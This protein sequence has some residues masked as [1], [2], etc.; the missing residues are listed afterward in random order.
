MGRT[1]CARGQ[2]APVTGPPTNALVVRVE[3]EKAIKGFVPQ[4]KIVEEMVQH[5]ILRLTGKTNEALAWQSLV[6]SKDVV[7]L[8]VYAEPGPSSGTRPAVV[9]AMIEGLLASGLPASN[10]IIWDKRLF[11]LRAMTRRSFTTTRSSA[12]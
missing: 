12:R 1:V 10:I 4:D 9:E 8:K 3:N 7:G 11:D 2:E 6:S 5:G